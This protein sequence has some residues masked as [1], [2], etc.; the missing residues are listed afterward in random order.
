MG[1]FIDLTGQKF[2]R[3]NVIRDSGKRNS[4]GAV[5]WECE[6]DCSRE[7]IH[8]VTTAS[9]KNGSSR[10][11]GCLQKEISAKTMSRTMKK[12]N[13]YDNSNN[14]YG[15]GYTSKGEE[16]YFDLEDY[17]KIKMYCWFINSDGYVCTNVYDKNKK[18]KAL[19]MHRVIMNCVNDKISVDHINHITHD[20]RKSN[21]RL[22]TQ[23]QNLMNR[24]ISKN[25]SSGVAGVYF[26]NH[27]NKWIAEI[28]INREKIRLGD[29]TSFDDAVTAR[30]N[31]E[32]ELFGEYSFDASCMA[33]S[34]IE[35]QLLE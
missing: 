9:L 22:A 26:D 10:S 25:N 27:R 12:Y 16:F 7:T 8:L 35:N 21:L 30:K 15:I 3:W 29:F 28:K 19:L 14:D 32:D 13:Q 17:E 11:C 2:D 6:C 18:R 4:Q 1:K 23:S 24:S 33:S 31:A 34:F 20:N 5:L